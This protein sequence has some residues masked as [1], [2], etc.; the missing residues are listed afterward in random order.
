MIAILT[1]GVSDAGVFAA[2]AL[3]LGRGAIVG[4]FIVAAAFLAGFAAIRQSGLAFCAFLMVVGA[5]AL[6]FSWLGFIPAISPNVSIFIMGL[7]AAAAIT[8]LSASISAARLNPILGGLMFTAA[9]IIAGMG[10]INFVD[11]IDVA[12]MMRWSVIGIGAF[13]VL[14]ALSQAFK[15]DSNA[16]LILP[17][18]AMAMAAPLL[19]PL[20]QLEASSFALAPHGL[21]TLGVLAASLV[22]L[23]ETGKAQLHD[24][25][26]SNDSVAHF[27]ERDI[28]DETNDIEHQQNYQSDAGGMHIQ[29]DGSLAKV[30]DY[31]G[32]AIWDWSP[33]AIDQTESLPELLGADSTAAFTP[34]ALTNFIHKKDISQFKKDVLAPVDGPFDV[35]LKLFD[36]RLLRIRG[37][38]AANE[39]AGEL[40]RI[41][42]FFETA[43]PQFKPSKDNGVSGRTVRQ[44]TA[45]AIV[46]TVAGGLAAKMAGALD[47]GDIVAAFQPIVGLKDNK[48]VGYEALARWRDQENGADEG[49]ETFVKAAETAGK[50][51]LLA[52]T[53]L[54][55]AAAFLSEKLD[56]N[57]RSKIF[58]AMNLSWTQMRETSFLDAVKDAV[59]E[60][61]LPKGSL[62]LEL[63]ESDAITEGEEAAGSIF[64]KLKSA[65]VALAFDDFGAG[66]SCLSNLRKY[67]FDFLKIDKSFA[68]DL[69]AGG[70]GSKIVGSLAGLG[71]DLG[72]KVIVEGIETSSAA[73]AAAKLGL[74]YG[75][76]Y[77][78]GKPEEKVHAV[79]KKSA[80]VE[81]S[82]LENDA[83]DT[84]AD[85]TA[86]A[87]ENDK[88]KPA[89]ETK[90]DEN[91]SAELA[92]AEMQ[93]E[94]TPEA[95]DKEASL[96]SDLA[97]TSPEDDRGKSGSSWLWRRGSMR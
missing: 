67:D 49:P 46:P 1:A 31:S 81:S 38:R 60:Y 22:A 16:R 93:P 76:G 45:A 74:D 68:A 59:K 26:L 83:A 15:G 35:A 7:F 82:G 88:E 96:A 18:I 73:K 53:M 66:F 57:K 62:V 91:T 65:G 24:H 86:Q 64:K 85:V 77:A 75:Q 21:F 20:T 94:L 29:L 71:K 42:A 25:G 95:I 50:A 70:D 58:V 3:D 5:A 40:E 69:E 39:D 97:E 12:P 72:L 23:T 11:R 48:T 8:F 27:A 19:G 4:A 80:A 56:E 92:E 37:A 17:G 10:V 47:N 32:V 51:N 78:L 9:L 14:L 28:F 44:A 33:N 89:V 52:Q 55:Q 63:T 2:P 87:G 79:E 90:A 41:V 13:G 6:Q 61:K 43:S 36:G 54:D 34:E 30:L 84:K